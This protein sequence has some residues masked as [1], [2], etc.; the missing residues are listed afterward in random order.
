MDIINFFKSCG[1]FIVCTMGRDCP[2]ARPFGAIME[3]KS[4]LYISTSQNKDVYKQLKVNGNIQLIAVKHS[5]RNWLRVTGFA[6]EC[7]D[8]KI[9]KI[10]LTECPELLKHFD[11]EQSE[12]F[13]LFQ[14]KPLK[15]ELKQGDKILME[16]KIFNKLVR[17]RIPEILDKNGGETETQILSNE[18]YIECL[19]EKLREECEEVITNDSR[20]NLTEELA[21]LLEVMNAIAKANSIDFGEIERIRTAKKEKRGGFENKIFLVSSNIVKI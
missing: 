18:K 20:E 5:T 6:Y 11:S 12:N 4:E 17:D 2:A 19:Y 7:T 10:M 8:L 14:I 21:D 15:I 1:N 13:V 16:R 9:K 3:Y